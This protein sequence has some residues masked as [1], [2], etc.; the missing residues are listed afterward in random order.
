MLIISCVEINIPEGVTNIISKDIATAFEMRLFC[1]VFLSQ[2]KL[3]CISLP[4]KLRNGAY[5]LYFNQVSSL[6]TSRNVKR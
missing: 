6:M 1:W 5:I 2:T 3:V 4:Y